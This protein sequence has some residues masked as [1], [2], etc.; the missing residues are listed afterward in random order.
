MYSRG[1]YTCAVVC[2]RRSEDKVGDSVPHHS[3]LGMGR[4]SPGSAASSFTHWPVSLAQFI[5]FEDRMQGIKLYTTQILC[6]VVP[7]WCCG[8]AASSWF[9]CAFS[10]YSGIPHFPGVAGWK[11]SNLR[12]ARARLL[13]RN[14]QQLTWE[15][16][17][18]LGGFSKV[19][20]DNHW[21][22]TSWK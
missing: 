22:L 4:R 20:Y 14:M 3:V 11:E 7:L 1:V 9:S 16:D 10:H 18:I 17:A 5:Y 15:T 21:F 8:V 19:A 2:E 12:C 13:T 6:A